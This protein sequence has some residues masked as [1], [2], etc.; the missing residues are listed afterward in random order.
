MA[1][2]GYAVLG[3][4]PLGAL[5]A[6]TTTG[7]AVLGYAV[8]GHMVLGQSGGA[9]TIGAATAGA[10]WCRGQH[11]HRYTLGDVVHL[12]WI[13]TDTDGQ[14][15]DPTTVTVTIQHETSGT[16]T[17]TDAVANPA[18]GDY[19]VAF[20]PSITG[21]FVAV[22]TATGDYAGVT[23]VLFDA[24]GVAL[25]LPTVAEVRAYLAPTTASDTA[26]TEALAVERDDQREWCRID[27]YTQALRAA[28]FRRVAKHLAVQ[29]VPTA[30]VTSFGQGATAGPALALAL[31]AEIERLERSRRRPGIA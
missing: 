12:R 24:D 23:T 25:G 20:K 10:E 27:P 17:L 1:V 31:D 29:K 7:G 11:R 26:I 8:L 28:L 9:I 6:V 16:A 21:R 30:Q 3:Q 13:V 15:A 2:L 22:L 19:Q 4:T 5:T 18:T 14:P